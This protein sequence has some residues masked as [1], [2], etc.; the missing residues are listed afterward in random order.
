MVTVLPVAALASAKVAVEEE[1]SRL[2]TSDPSMP[3]IAP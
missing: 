2:T 1:G 3:L